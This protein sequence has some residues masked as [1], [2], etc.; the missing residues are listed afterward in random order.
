MTLISSSDETWVGSEL[1]LLTPS[2]F[3]VSSPTYEQL[4]FHEYLPLVSLSDSLSTPSLSRLTSPISLFFHI[5]LLFPHIPFGHSFELISTPYSSSSPKGNQYSRHTI[6]FVQANLADPNLK[7]STYFL[8][9]ILT[10]SPVFHPS[11][12]LLAP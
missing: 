1:P 11:H 4:T 7:Q 6:L 12:G 3:M 5:S 8:P 2:T 10:F 9:S